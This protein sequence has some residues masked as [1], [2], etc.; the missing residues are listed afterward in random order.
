MLLQGQPKVRNFSALLKLVKR[1]QTKFHAHLMRESQVS[2]S[3][4][5]TVATIQIIKNADN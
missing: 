3:K 1:P 2:R 4:K 5:S